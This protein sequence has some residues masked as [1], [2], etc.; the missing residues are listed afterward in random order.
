MHLINFWACF[1]FS[2]GHF[3]LWNIKK[4]CV[5]KKLSLNSLQ[6]IRHK[7]GFFGQNFEVSPLTSIPSKFSMDWQLISMDRIIFSE[8]SCN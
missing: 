1:S 7:G 3:G 8:A 6:H 4:I 2:I 5:E